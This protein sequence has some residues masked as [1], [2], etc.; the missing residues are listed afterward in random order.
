MELYSIKSET[1]QEK[2]NEHIRIPVSPMVVVDPAP[3]I[4]LVLPLLPFV[5]PF[6]VLKIL[7]PGTSG[8]TDATFGKFGESA[9]SV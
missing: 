3:F 8:P 6:R 5:Q 2:S 4:P 1:G 9:P 7:V